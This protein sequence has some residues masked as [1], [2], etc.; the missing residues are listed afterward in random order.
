IYNL[1]KQVINQAYDKNSELDIE[2]IQFYLGINLFDLSRKYKSTTKA[3]S[4]YN[5]SGR[6]IF[7]PSYSVGKILDYE[8]PDVIVV[9]YGQRMEKTM[10]VESNKRGRDVIRI[11]DLLG[12]NMIIPYNAKECVMNKYAKKNLLQNNNHI[13]A[14]DIYVT[15]QPNLESK[16]DVN[17]LKYIFK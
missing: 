17:D 16:Y 9:T 11:V 2:D 13:M 8:M 12:E 14:E 5:K 7:N 10:A 15:G 1:S 4:E 6:S 3:L